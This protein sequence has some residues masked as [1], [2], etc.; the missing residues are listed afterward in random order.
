[1]HLYLLYARTKYAV[2]TLAAAQKKGKGSQSHKAMM[3]SKPDLFL[4]ARV[5]HGGFLVRA[6]VL[7]FLT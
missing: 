4:R 1:M 2:C 3:S 7:V 5:G 6:H